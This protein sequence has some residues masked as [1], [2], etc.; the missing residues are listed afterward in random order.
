MDSIRKLAVLS[1]G[2]ACFFAGLAVWAVMMALIFDPPQAFRVGAALV[3]ILACVLTIKAR[4]APQ[5]PYRDTEVWLLMDR[6]SDWPEHRIQ[7]AIGGVLAETYGRYARYAFAIA[8]SF[9][10]LA[11]AADAIWPDD[12]S[13][14]EG[15]N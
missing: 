8:V 15:L 3:L 9:W 14:L 10:L 5:R 4:N 6:Q 13:D 7:Q 1:V 2:R 12:V 11:I